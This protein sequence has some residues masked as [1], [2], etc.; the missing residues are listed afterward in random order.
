MWA[1]SLPTRGGRN[2]YSL[3]TM[4]LLCYLLILYS[5]YVLSTIVCDDVYVPHVL[6]EAG[7]PDRGERVLRRQ[8]I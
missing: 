1:A 6:E 7:P 2:R 4:L 8:P 5:M 3:L